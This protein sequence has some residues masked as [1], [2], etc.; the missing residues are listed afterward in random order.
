MRQHGDVVITAPDEYSGAEQLGRPLHLIQPEV[1][2]VE[3]D[4]IDEAWAVNAAPGA[5]RHCSPASVPSVRSALSSPESTHPAPTSAGPSTTRGTVGWGSPPPPAMATSAAS[6][7]A[8]AVAGFGVE[9][10]GWDG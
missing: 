2:R 6:P 9:G 10:R 5:R 7:S 8:Q 4:G 3:V 1:C